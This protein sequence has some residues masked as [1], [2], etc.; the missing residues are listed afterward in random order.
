VSGGNPDA[1]GGGPIGARNRRERGL[2]LLAVLWLV[3]LLS[4]VAAS[5][6]ATSRTET[7]LARNAVERARAEALADAGLYRALFGLLEPAP[8]RRWRTDGTVYT[9]ALGAGEV[10]VAVQDEAGRID[11]NVATDELIHG[12]FLSAGLDGAGADALLDALA[13]FRDPDDLRRPGGAEDADYRAA[14]LP[15]G[16]KDAPFEAV[17]EL[18]QVLGMTPELYR[19]VAPL[20][21]VYSWQ[22][23]IDPL[24][25]PPEVLLALP[26]IGPARVEAILAARAGTARGLDPLELAA[27]GPGLGF[28]VAGAAD[29][30]RGVGARRAEIAGDLDVD[31]D[32]AADPSLAEYEGLLTGFG[33]TVFR[34]RAAARTAAGTVFVREAVAAVDAAG[35][36]YTFYSWKRGEAAV[37]PGN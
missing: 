25:A 23:G 24:T 11:L 9:L 14:G 28:G 15:Y 12:L 35:E 18:Q 27:A 10:G 3:T 22:D 21:T 6:S 1:H 33:G 37:P 32:I 36:P 34:V 17:E 13:D 2:A 30:R 20:V 4:V 8:D 19:H 7:Q 26:G 5:F 16:A 29:A 31:R